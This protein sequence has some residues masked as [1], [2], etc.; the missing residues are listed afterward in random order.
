MMTL[1]E[2]NYASE[3]DGRGSPRPSISPF[4]ELVGPFGLCKIPGNNFGA[5]LTNLGLA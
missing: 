4:L 5:T 3:M 2:R 1:C